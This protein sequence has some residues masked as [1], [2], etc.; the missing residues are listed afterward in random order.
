MTPRCSNRIF[1]PISISIIPP[2]MTALFLYLTPNI[3]PTF[4][5]IAEII[6]VVAPINDTAATMLTSGSSAKVTP[7]ASASILVATAKINIETK[8]NESPDESSSGENASLII[9]IP[10]SAKSPKAIQWSKELMYFLN[11]EPKKYP[12]VGIR[13]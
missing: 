6:N 10:I 8:A 3:L 2:A 13:A 1:N 12:I 9:L 5:P 11:A 7:T 4:K